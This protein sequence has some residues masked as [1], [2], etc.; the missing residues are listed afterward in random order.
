MK[1]LAILAVIFASLSIFIPVGG[2]WIA[3]ICSILAMISF[4]S[5]TTLSG[6]AFSINIINTALLSPSLI[7]VEGAGVASGTPN[8]MYFLCVGFHVTLLIVSIVWCLVR[9]IFKA[10]G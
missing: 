3:M 5:Q 2:L 10:K 7:M 4:R 9:K 8:D 6:I 1:A